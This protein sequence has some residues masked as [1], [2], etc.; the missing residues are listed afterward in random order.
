[1]SIR[2]TEN[3]S[4][5]PF[6]PPAQADGAE[7]EELRD[8]AAVR[9]AFYRAVTGRDDEDLTADELLPVIRSDEDE[10]HLIW[11]VRVNGELVGQAMVELP[12][13]QGSRTAYVGIEL[14]PRVW[15]QGIGS[16]I[17]LHL[18]AVARDN[19]RSILHC[20]AEQPASDGPTLAAPTGFGSVPHDHTARFCLQQGFTLEQVERVSTLELT[21]EALAGVEALLREAEAASAGYR[22]VQWMLPTPAERTAGYAWMKSRMSTD[23][24][25]ADLV[26]DEEVW[27]AARVERHDERYLA[28]GRT[29]QVTAAEHIATGELCAFNELVIGMDPGAATHQEDTLVLSTHRGHRLGMLVKCAGLLSWREVAPESPLVITYNAEENRPMLAINEAIG[30]R[31]VAYVGAWKKAL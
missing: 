14:L 19:E 5:H 22:V 4:L 24:P 18:E 23:A 12:L 15:G 26:L 29:V 25:A 11:T 31:P 30:F 8:L 10:V 13:E 28:G 17:W 21:P 1:M 6:T 2:L 3:A 16:A 27:D 20:W 9:N 7:G